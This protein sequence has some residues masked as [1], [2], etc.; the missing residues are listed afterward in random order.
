MYVD[1]AFLL[2]SS[3]NTFLVPTSHECQKEMVLGLRG[4]EKHSTPLPEDGGARKWAMK[5]K[6]DA[7]TKS[8]NIGKFFYLP[9]DLVRKYNDLGP[10]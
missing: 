1:L 2:N 4:D 7:K 3:F 10:E 8:R 5:K 6:H 9:R